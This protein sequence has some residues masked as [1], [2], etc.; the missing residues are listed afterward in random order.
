MSDSE[1]TDELDKYGVW[2]K[3]DAD[4]ADATPA[5]FSLDAELPD[6]SSLDA[7]GPASAEADATEEDISLDEFIAGGEFEGVAEG[8]RGYGQE[9][10]PAQPD[11]AADFGMNTLNDTGVTTPTGDVP[12]DIDLSF[13]DGAGIFA[14]ESAAT[15][16]AEEPTTDAASNDLDA[17]T[18]SIDLSAFGFDD[19]TADEQPAPAAETETAPEA[20][21]DSFDDM[22]NALGDGGTMDASAFFDDD[23]AEPPAESAPAPAAQPASP[24]EESVDLSDFG[25]DDASTEGQGEVKDGTK[26]AAAQEDY[27]MTVTADD[28]E[29]APPL[30][31]PQESV[32]APA[33]SETHD[34]SAEPPVPQAVP[35]AATDSLLSKIMGELDALRGE[36]AQLKN[37]FAVMQTKGISEP[38]AKEAETPVEATDDVPDIPAPAQTEPTTGG[39]FDDNGEDETIALSTDEMTNIMNNA[40]FQSETVETGDEPAA[41]EPPVETDDGDANFDATTQVQTPD[42]P[43]EIFLPKT[44][45]ATTEESSTTDAISSEESAPPLSES[46]PIAGADEP[47]SE[48]AVAEEP[49]ATDAATVPQE[50]SAAETVGV[51][52]G[53][54]GD[55]KQEIKSVLS[56]MDQL[57][58]NLP[59]DKITEFAHSE[60]FEAYKKLFKELGLA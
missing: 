26:Q 25:F 16:T 14:T 56:Y 38:A 10:A 21:A 54:S 39:F 31:A 20:N 17:G 8:N 18:E 43:N 59:E 12:L 15:D 50:S 3:K 19:S 1:K 46:E 30:F 60:Q 35:D 51:D 40:D 6:L 36:I 48:S 47:S 58:E 2:I 42:L 44:D 24:D 28:D 49:P 23:S 13:D 7:L 33:E 27:E 57:L 32:S 9:Q 53:I 5:D 41:A 45:E 29:P 55:L 22:F 52:S 4:S 34:V 11:T 37:D